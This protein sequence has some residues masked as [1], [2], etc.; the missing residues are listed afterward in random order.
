MEV[1][2]FTVSFTPANYEQNQLIPVSIL[3]TGNISKNRQHS[4]VCQISPLLLKASQ[5][6]HQVNTSCNSLTTERNL[7]STLHLTPCETLSFWWHSDH[8]KAQTSFNSPCFWLCLRLGPLIDAVVHTHT[9][10]LNLCSSLHM[11]KSWPLFYFQNTF[12]ST[13]FWLPL[14][15][16]QTLTILLYR[17]FPTN[18]RKRTLLNFRSKKSRPVIKSLNFHWCRAVL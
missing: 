12:I 6:L 10:T 11:Y 1:E 16:T 5:A 14:Q 7:T 13:V 15:P 18:N 4:Y 2:R 17:S 8:L 9:Y 3:T